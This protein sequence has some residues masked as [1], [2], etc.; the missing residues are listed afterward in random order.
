MKDLVDENIVQPI[1]DVDWEAVG[2]DIHDW[3]DE[4]IVQELKDVDWDAIGDGVM[5][6]LADA[7]SKVKLI[8][9]PAQTHIFKL[10]PANI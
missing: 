8:S 4:K 7:S 5:D 3:V 9:K 1:S 6:F 2:L 10:F